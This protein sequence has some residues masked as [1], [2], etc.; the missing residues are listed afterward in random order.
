MRSLMSTA[1][2]SL[3]TPES[4]LTSMINVAI[5]SDVCGVVDQAVLHL[6]HCGCIIVR[7]A[8]SL[9][10]CNVTIEGAALSHDSGCPFSRV[11]RVRSICNPSCLRS[12]AIAIPSQSTVTKE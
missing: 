11:Q 10:L 8:S 12:L 6:A 9:S 1:V 5:V 7:C 4:K 2:D 3:W